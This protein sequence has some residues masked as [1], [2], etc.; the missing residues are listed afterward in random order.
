MW[1]PTDC[2][3]INCNV[4]E[5]VKRILQHSD[6]NKSPYDLHYLIDFKIVLEKNT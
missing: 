3:L 2:T 4:E 6:V 5:V 1:Q